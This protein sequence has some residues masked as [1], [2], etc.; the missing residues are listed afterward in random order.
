MEETLL[1][2]WGKPVRRF[3]AFICN[4]LTQYVKTFSLTFNVA[5]VHAEPR[6]FPAR[7]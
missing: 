4:G 1:L 7:D 3:S 2:R 6:S 5:R